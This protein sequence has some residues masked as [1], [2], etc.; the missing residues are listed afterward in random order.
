MFSSILFSTVSLCTTLLSSIHMFLEC[1]KHLSSK[2]QQNM[3]QPFI[4]LTCLLPQCMASILK[5]ILWSHRPVLTE[6]EEGRPCAHRFLKIIMY[7]V[8]LLLPEVT[9]I[10]LS[11]TMFHLDTMHAQ[12]NTSKYWHSMEGHLPICYPKT[13]VLWSP[14]TPHNHDIGSEHHVLWS[15]HPMALLLLSKTKQTHITFLYSKI[16]LPE[17]ETTRCNIFAKTNSTI[18]S[19]LY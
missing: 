12:I 19:A 14:T 5:W 7:L 8:Y 1:P 9:G 11:A 3:H 16:Y 15:W 6:Q 17:K 18:I 4:W 13:L 10:P 2:C